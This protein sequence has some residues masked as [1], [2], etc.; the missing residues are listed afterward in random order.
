MHT[1]S[2]I[3]VERNDRSTSDAVDI[4]RLAPPLSIAAVWATVHRLAAGGSLATVVEG[5]RT[6][7]ADAARVA[8]CAGSPAQ[9]VEGRRPGWG[10]GRG[11][12]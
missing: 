7:D 10:D 4:R 8:S 3:A 6:S 5:A 1:G 11:R 2:L 12:R 9:G